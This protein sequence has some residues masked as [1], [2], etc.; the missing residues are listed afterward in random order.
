MPTYEYRCDDCGHEFEAFQTI[1]EKP[2]EKCPACNG[3]V[4]RLI[5]G[6]A[7]LLFK[8]SGFY[9]TDYRSESYK[10]AKDIITTQMKAV[11]EVMSIGKTFKESLHK[12]IR[13][14]EIKRYGLGREEFK[15]LNLEQIKERLVLPSIAPGR[16]PA[17]SKIWKPLQIPMTSPPPPA[18][19]ATASIIG[20]KR[21]IAP[22][23]R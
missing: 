22:Q 7:G 10:K 3:K 15:K 21:A 19:S 23:R 9:I 11:G 1:T 6:G 17:S 20:L 4:R 13:S 5:S 2:V 14:L 8:G 16:S 12:A 18:K